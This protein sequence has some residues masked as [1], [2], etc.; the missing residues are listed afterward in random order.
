MSPSGDKVAVPTNGHRPPLTD[1]EADADLAE[2]TDLGA[3]DPNLESVGPVRPLAASIPP[4][5]SG[6]LAAGLG[7]VAALIVLVLGRRRFGG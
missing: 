2:T 5:S 3:G 6:Q 1:P 4:V 7:I